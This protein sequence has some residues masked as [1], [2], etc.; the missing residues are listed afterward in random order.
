MSLCIS[1]GIHFFF[2]NL[3][4]NKSWT[5]T[6]VKLQDK[7]SDPDHQSTYK[8]NMEDSGKFALYLLKNTLIR[9]IEILG[10][11][12]KGEGHTTHQ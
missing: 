7:Y 5:P 9:F 6:N 1:I 2:A 4:V 3:L 12:M 10:T 11:F 8:A